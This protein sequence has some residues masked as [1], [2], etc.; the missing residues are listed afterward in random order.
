M[1]AARRTHLLRGLARNPSTPPGLV[2]ELIGEPDALRELCRWREDLTADLAEAI[3]AAGGP[4]GGR[5]DGPAA[6][7]GI[8]DWLGDNGSL[9]VEVM[10]FLARQPDPAIRQAAV[11]YDSWVGAPVSDVPVD[12]LE[13][14]ADDPDPMVRWA[15]VAHPHTPPEILAR[16]AA[17]PEDR[18]RAKVAATWWHPPERVRRQLLTDPAAATRNWA[19]AERPPADLLPGLFADPAT[20]FK[21][22]P[23]VTL[24]PELAEELSEDPTMRPALAAHPELPEKIRDRLVDDPDCRVGLLTNPTT[25]TELRLRLYQPKDRAI[26]VGLRWLSAAPLAER[27]T[28]LDSPLP[29]LRLEVA[30]GDDLPP[31]AVERLLRDEDPGVRR[32][33]ARH[34][35]VPAGALEALVGEYP[36]FRSLLDHPRFPRD[37]FARFAGSPV[38]AVRAIACH[39]PDLPADV[40]ARLAADE[41]VDV[42]RA[43]AEHPHLPA[44][45]LSRLLREDDPRVAEAAAANP[46]LPVGTMAALLTHD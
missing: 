21:A 4:P 17:D 28:Y 37:A 34:D 36:A 40:V 14:L 10:W 6:G 38:A 2:R 32:V 1:D 19:L 43:A 12:L 15:V 46:A 33:A 9:S 7:T 23:Y 20:R 13:F 18:V 16:L 31:E 35:D 25:P 22:L 29:F 44:D 5:T 11:L 30:R 42:R 27:L 8:A 39:D 41:D 3:V 26:R 45:L 24:T